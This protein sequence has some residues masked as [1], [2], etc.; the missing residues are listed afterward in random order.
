MTFKALIVEH[1]IR[2][3]VLFIRIVVRKA[4]ISVF[5]LRDFCQILFKFND[6]NKYEILNKV[7]RIY[8]T[9]Y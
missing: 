3:F 8:I 4:F 7:Y 5:S 9:F 2:K 6:V 1:R